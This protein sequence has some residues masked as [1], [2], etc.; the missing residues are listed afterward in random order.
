MFE[1]LL[2]DWQ[3]PRNPESCGP[4][5]QPKSSNGYRTQLHKNLVNQML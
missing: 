4:L 1:S 3:W 5:P 2:P